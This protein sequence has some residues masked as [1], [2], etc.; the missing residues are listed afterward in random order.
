MK[1]HPSFQA[2]VKDNE[3]RA[4]IIIIFILKYKIRI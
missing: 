3:I 1:F 4:L 2:L